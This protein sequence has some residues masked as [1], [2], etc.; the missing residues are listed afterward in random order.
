MTSSG[1][2]VNIGGN[3][4]DN[5]KLNPNLMA[6]KNIDGNNYYDMTLFQQADE[7]FYLDAAY[8][9]SC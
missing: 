3:P 5:L 7:L 6:I 4:W 8:L 2:I 1:T 9:L